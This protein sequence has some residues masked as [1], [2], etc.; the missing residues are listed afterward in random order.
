MATKKKTAAKQSL[1]L[2]P[3]TTPPAFTPPP[4][5][6]VTVQEPQYPDTGI[7]GGYAKVRLDNKSFILKKQIP[8]R[9]NYYHNAATSFNDSR[10]QISIPAGKRLF[11]TGIYIH[12]AG[13][14]PTAAG[15]PSY[16]S[17][18]FENLINGGYV[19]LIEYLVTNSS[20]LFMTFAPS[21]A[22][23][24]TNLYYQLN[25]TGDKCLTK[26]EIYG[27]LEDY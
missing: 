11:I 13:T 12:A 2:E 9:F 6:Q 10:Y 3:F 5:Q 18:V 26:F 4:Q 21:W 22:V 8:W 23:D 16:G 24:G 1:A 19:Q 7:Y 14:T 27:F 15:Y 20:D 25:N 17:V